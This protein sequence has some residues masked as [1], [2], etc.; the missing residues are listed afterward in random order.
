M[1]NHLPKTSQDFSG[2]SGILTG[3]HMFGYLLLC[4]KL[5]KMERL[6]TTTIL[7]S[8][9]ILQVDWTELGGYFAPQNIICSCSHL[10]VERGAVMS[11]MVLYKAGT[12]C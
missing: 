1:L 7:L 10:A 2:R 6:K 12:Q 8:L 5:S 9:M 11:E 4:N 3:V